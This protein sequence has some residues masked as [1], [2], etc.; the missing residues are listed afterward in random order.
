MPTLFDDA[1]RAALTARLQSL[2][3]GAT[4]QWGKMNAA[5]MLC[6]CAHALEVATGDRVLKQALIGKLL[7]PFV[8]KSIL[9]DKPFSKSSP[10]DPTFVVSDERDFAAEKTRLLG[11]MER[12]AQRGVEAAGTAMHSFFGKLSGD[13]WGRLMYK[14]VDHHL[15][16]FSS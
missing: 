10:T 3:P 8:R 12:F 5:Q 1:D 11:L 2:Q 16:Q 13:E 6:H 4:R 7:S 9:G 14:H 15:R